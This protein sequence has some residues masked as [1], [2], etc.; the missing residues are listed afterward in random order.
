MFVITQLA[1]IL[2]F[3][4][5]IFNDKS[6]VCNNFDKKMDGL[7][8]FWAIFSQTHLVTLPLNAN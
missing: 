6:Y 1:H 7:G 4:I 2:A 5:F 8:T 3:F